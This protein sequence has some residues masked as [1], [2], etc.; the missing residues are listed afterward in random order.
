MNIEKENVM[1]NRTVIKNLTALLMAALL[2]VGTVTAASAAPVTS[3]APTEANVHSVGYMNV[4]EPEPT[5]GIGGEATVDPVIL[6]CSGKLPFQ[7]NG[8]FVDIPDSTLEGTYEF[9]TYKDGTRCM[10]ITPSEN[11]EKFSLYRLMFALQ[12]DYRKEEN[13]FMRVTYMTE[14]PM[15][16]SMT[17]VN[18]ASRGDSR[19]I[20]ENNTMGSNGKW[21][22][23]APVNIGASSVHTRFVSGSHNTLE[24]MSDSKDSAFYIKE[25]AFFSSE[26]QAYEYYGEPVP[27]HISSPVV[28]LTFGEGGTANVLEGPDWGVNKIDNDNKTIEITYAEKTN[29]GINYMAK[30]GFANSVKS[31]LSLDFRYVRVYYAADNPDGC[32]GVDLYMT[33]D[34]MG[35]RI[36]LDENIEDTNGEFV[37]S[38]TVFMPKVTTERIMGDGVTS[39]PMH[40]S[41]STNAKLDGGKYTIKA[42]YFFKNRADADAFVPGEAAGTKVTLNGNDIAKYQIVIPEGTLSAKTAAESLAEHI[43]TTVGV[44]LPIVDDTSAETEYEIL[45]GVSERNGSDAGLDKTGEKPW[46][47]YA[48]STV[49]NKLVITAENPYAVIAGVDKFMSSFLY[50]GMT[51]LPD[52]IE[53]KDVSYVGTSSMI[54][55]FDK[56]ERIGNVEDPAAFTEDFDTDE[57]YFAESNGAD[58]WKY[59]GGVYT[60]DAGDERADTYIQA[61][62]ANVKLGAKISYTKADKNGDMG[63]LLRYTAKDSYVRAGYD[64]ENGEW[65]IE[66][67]EGNDFGTVRAASKKVSITANKWYELEFTV[68]GGKATLTV[69]GKEILT[70]SDIA[71]VTPGKIGVFAENASV[72]VDD[73]DV[74]FMSGMATVMR[75]VA[76]T[77]LPDELFREGG[78]VVEKADG[79]LIFTTHHS[80]AIYQSTDGGMTWTAS[81]DTSFLTTSQ[82]PG[83]LKLTD[84][85]WITTDRATVNG[86]QY[87]ISKTSDDDGKTWVNGGIITVGTYP[88]DGEGGSTAYA[89]NMNDKITQMATTGRIFY[90]QNYEVTDRSKPNAGRIVFCEFFY[91]DDKGSTWTKSETGSWQIEGNEDEAWFG[92][93]KILECA[94]GTLR[95]YNSWNDYGC[96][97]YSES[98]DGG[99]T[100]GPIVE[101]PEFVCA[102]SS[103]QFC[104]DPYAENNTTYYMVWVNTEQEEGTSGAS[105]TMTRGRLSLAKSTDGKSWSYIGDLWH[106][107]MNYRFGNILAHIVDPFVVATKDSVIVGTGLA[108]YLPVTG[109][110]SN[111]HGA[112]REHIW[113]IDRKTV[114]E[115]AKPMNKFT[116]MDLGAPYYSA[117]TYV[118]ENGLFNGTSATTFAPDTVMNRAMFVTVLGRLSKADVSKYTTPTFSDVKAGQW[119]TSYVEWAA[120]NGIVNGMG[121]GIYGIDGSV[122]V[123]QACT[124]LYR[125]SGGKSAV[126]SGMTISDFVDAASVSDWAA[127]GVKWAVENGI[128]DGIADSLSPKTPASRA[129]VA[130]M[131]ANYVTNIG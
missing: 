52:V 97:V 35:E 102:K 86:V 105:S 61:F 47:E 54:T 12:K 24:F 55:R 66:Q 112:Q 109:D 9:V 121:G 60:A 89:G 3:T 50:K 44:K 73:I 72:S 59:S 127:E 6:D 2:S 26:A 67:R 51:E 29:Q 81:D 99:V 100:W 83:F 94:D 40:V 7:F 101:M 123:E 17:I 38:D 115:T 1:K 65:Y 128:Y 16:A 49:G 34:K 48:I 130:M 14:D 4:T 71:Q 103:M 45:I 77:R 90:S 20:L 111:G 70:A 93:C 32:M 53:V 28:A 106:W 117:V 76:H 124:I 104:R 46:N 58:V 119:Y 69:D 95:M 23:T 63:L 19:V 15:A 98:K 85:S 92:E 118:S 36:L 33:N 84:G 122:T 25:I 96:I 107:R 31:K 131:F 87:V 79:T 21:I 110:K 27:E 30:A 41:F 43:K 114:D 42:V 125:Y 75:N 82:Y 91:S 5:P 68:D 108:E 10:K 22:R 120:A 126:A 39:G 18:N 62:D 37:L 64:F 116:D 80:K 78:S 129:V 56:W 57:G 74:L 11:V 8:V 13:K 113:V 88:T